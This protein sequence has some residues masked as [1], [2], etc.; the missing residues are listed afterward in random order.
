[1]GAR[2]GVF[3]GAADARHQLATA[4]LRVGRAHGGQL[5]QCVHLARLVAVQRAAQCFGIALELG[6][7]ALQAIAAHIAARALVHKA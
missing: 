4:H 5:G 3:L 6:V 2:I 7:T 1:M